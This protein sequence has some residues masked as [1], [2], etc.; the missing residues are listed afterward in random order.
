MTNHLAA[1][2]TTGMTIGRD[3]HLNA[4]LGISFS[5]TRYFSRRMMSDYICWSMERFDRLMIIIADQLEAHNVSIFRQL[6]LEDARERTRQTGIELRRGYQRAIPP[7]TNGRVAVSLASDL[8][9]NHRCAETLAM[10]RSYAQESPVFR[11]DLGRAVS[12]GLGGKIQ[13][14]REAG[15]PIGARELRLLRNYLI[16]ELA[17]I[18]YVSHQAEV[19]FPVLLYPHFIPD[20][21]RNVYNG[22]YAGRF[23]SITGGE[24]FRSVRVVDSRTHP[25]ASAS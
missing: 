24:P 3:S 13:Q 10:V 8:L 4:N 11:S 16:E 14:A 22:A 23:A 25:L 5:K 9:A 17:I 12:E 21:V 7:E 18:L 6:S 2:G 20:V 15:V 1:L 19:R